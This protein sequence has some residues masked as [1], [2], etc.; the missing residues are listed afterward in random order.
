MYQRALQNIADVATNEKPSRR[1]GALPI[2]SITPQAIDKIYERLKVGAKGSRLRQANKAM[3]VLRRAWRVVQRRYPDTVPATNPVQGLERER[4]S[5]TIKPATRS[6][7]YAL[8]EE[9]KKIGHPHLGVAALICF[10]WHQRPE[11]VISGK[12][13]WADYR[14]VEMSRHVRIA[15]PKTGAEVWLP[16]E[17]REGDLFP[18]IEKYLSKLPKLGLPIVLTPGLRGPSRPYS[19]PHAAHT[20]ARAKRILAFQLM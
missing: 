1:I 16:L 18:E 6:E 8:A 5:E 11:H 12:I 15:H 3:D 17:D 14:P 7:A 13:T 20:V 4:R 19:F 9:L 10:E 2:E